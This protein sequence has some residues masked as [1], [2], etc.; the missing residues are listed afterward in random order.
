MFTGEQ[1]ALHGI[2]VESHR[3]LSY[4]QGLHK[5]QEKGGIYDC[6]EVYPKNAQV[7]RVVCN[8]LSIQNQR[9][10]IESLG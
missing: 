8:R 4:F 2:L 6:K 7:K 9:K 10:K 1:G 3:S 5:N